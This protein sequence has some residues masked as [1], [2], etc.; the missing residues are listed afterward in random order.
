MATRIKTVQ[1]AFPALASLVNNT[2]TTLTPITIYLPEASKGFRSVVAKVTCDDIVTATGGTITTKTVNLRLGAAAYTSYTNAATITNSGENISLAWER[3]VTNHFQT[4]WTGASMSCD[5]Q[6]QINQ[7]TG[8]TLGMVNVCVTL[9]ITYE[10]DDTSPTKVKTI[11]YPLDCPNGALPTAVATADTIPAL[12]TLLPEAG[13]VYRDIFVVFQGNEHNN[14]GTT[15]HTMTLR[16]GTATVTTGNYEAAL[17]SD[18]FTRYVWKLLGTYPSTA[19]S[20]TW[21]PTS[22]VATRRHHQQAYLVVTYEYDEASTTSVFNSIMVPFKTGVVGSSISAPAAIRMMLGSFEEPGSVGVRSAFYGFFNPLASVG[23][24]IFRYVNAAT[25]SNLTQTYAGLGSN[26]SGQSAFMAL[27]NEATTQQALAPAPAISYLNAEVYETDATDRVFDLSG[28]LIFCYTSNKS[29]FGT[30]SHRTTV[31]FNMVDF[32]AAAPTDV[33][34]SAFSEPLSV[35]VL[36]G[37][38][39]FITSIGFRVGMMPN[40]GTASGTLKL[41]GGNFSVQPFPIADW[42]L[43]VDP[44]VGFYEFFVEA[45]ELFTLHPYDNQTEGVPI[46]HNTGDGFSA[47]AAVLDA[48]T[49]GSRF[50][51]ITLM[52][53]IQ[54][55]Y[56]TL[57]GTLTGAT[58]GVSMYARSI[59]E[60]VRFTRVDDFRPAGSTTFSLRVPSRTAQFEVLAFDS[61]SKI[62]QGFG[63]PS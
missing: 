30:A 11:Y 45:L 1:Y 52:M 41:Y 9:E 23:N 3:N 2:L 54:H 46:R 29:V 36:S 38:D 16:V 49:T 58:G 28:F 44:E 60:I 42:S 27:I 26:Y 56:G 15:D 40:S 61:G 33:V 53:T 4:N 51:S 32:P 18:R 12:D 7:S 39:H 63:V 14:G 21:Q 6:L 31:L 55:V 34:T 62:A 22:S 17:G 13:K 8:T 57:T 47:S 43:R 59:D 25:G 10:F 5:V 19:A 35:A 48:T 20:Q 50:L 37:Q 24:L